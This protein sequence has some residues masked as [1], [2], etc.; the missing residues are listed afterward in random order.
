MHG[1]LFVAFAPELGNNKFHVF[2]VLGLKRPR[3]RIF[4]IILVSLLIVTSSGLVFGGWYLRQLEET[5]AAKFEGQKWR[6]P[7]K[8]YSD[9]H[10]LYVGINLRFQDLSEKLRRLG[11]HESQSAPNARGVSF[12]AVSWTLRSLSPRLFLPHGRL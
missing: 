6:F 10:L 11:Y 4:R 7:S 5:V 1:P 2:G 8:I 9:S 12:A 3:L